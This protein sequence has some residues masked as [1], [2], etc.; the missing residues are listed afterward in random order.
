MAEYLGNTSDIVDWDKFI[1]E[2][3]S[4]EPMIGYQFDEDRSASVD[5]AVL[6]TQVAWSTAGYPVEDRTHNSPIAWEAWYSGVHF[7]NAIQDKICSMIGIVPIDVSMVT[8]LVPGRFAPWHWDIRDAETIERFNSYNKPIVRIHIHMN[9]PAAGHVFV[10][11]DHC[12][13]NEEQGSIYKWPSW[14]CYHAGANCGLVSK[15]QFSI[16]GVKDEPK[17]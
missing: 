9:R 5:P 12:F 10:V 7:D 6:A 2:L 14:N 8:R 3:E 15:Y 16:I 11:E 4:I 1:T 13:Y 17:D